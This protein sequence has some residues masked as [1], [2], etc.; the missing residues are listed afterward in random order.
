[1]RSFISNIPPHYQYLHSW[2][3]ILGSA[4][5]G[6]QP[7][8]QDII[9]AFHVHHTAGANIWTHYGKVLMRKCG[10]SNKTF[11]IKCS[12]DIARFLAEHNLTAREPTITT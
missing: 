2:H 9:Y 1:M 10:Q 5:K 8:S 6:N 3:L 12:N 4:T 7:H 11:E